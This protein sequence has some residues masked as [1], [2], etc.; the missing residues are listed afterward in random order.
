MSGVR[1]AEDERPARRV[2]AVSVKKR[3]SSG[4]WRV[5]APW[6]VVR[7]GVPVPVNRIADHLART[8]SL[9]TWATDIHVWVH[10]W[11]TP[12]AQATKAAV[13]LLGRARELYEVNPDRYP[14]L[15]VDYRP[16]CV[17]VRR[18]SSSRSK[19]NG[20]TSAS[21]TARTR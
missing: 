20:G 12:P 5:R 9:Q 4:S 1:V 15:K 8:I 11:Q 17:V 16:W 2:P 7:S 18:P 19:L 13:K 6:S 3:K 21:A 10:G 14:D